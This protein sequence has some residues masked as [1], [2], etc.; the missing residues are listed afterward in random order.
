[1]GRRWRPFWEFVLFVA[2][3]LVL[4]GFILTFLISS[5]YAIVKALQ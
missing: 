5:I 3:W 1:M 2:G 4:I